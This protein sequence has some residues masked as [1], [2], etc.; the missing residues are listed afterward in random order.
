MD[1]NKIK[2]AAQNYEADMTKFLREI[3]KFPGESCGE[4]DHIERIAEEMRKLDFDKVEIDPQGNVL[5][6]MG[7][8]ETLIGF[9]AHI[10]T[11]GIGNRDNW[12]FN[13]Y[14]GFESDTEIGGRG[15]SDQLGGIVSAVYGARIMK[16]LG[17]LS[18]K[19]TV[20]V[21]GTVQ[22][23]DC[24]GS[25]GN[26]SSTKIKSVRNLW[27]PQNRLTAVSTADREDVWRSV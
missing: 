16:D 27:Y 7:T 9:D 2:E 23:E 21:T 11:V 6:Y 12:E 24:D 10:D 4:K 8:G 26:T 5:G 13:P 20:L 14:E 15:T 1:F 19:Y 17:L 3:V 18:D 25:A 22:E